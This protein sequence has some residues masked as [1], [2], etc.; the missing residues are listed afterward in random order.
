MTELPPELLRDEVTVHSS[1]RHFHKHVRRSGVV[2]VDSLD[3]A[4]KEA[5][6]IVQAGIRPHQV[7]ELGELLIVRDASRGEGDN[8]ED[9]KSLRDWVERGNVIFKSVGMGLMDLVT[10]GDLV[11]LAREKGVG[12]TLEEF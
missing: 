6:E 1:H 12:T 11:R 3:A 10:G 7:V 2:V 5:G 8:S 4:L 9:G